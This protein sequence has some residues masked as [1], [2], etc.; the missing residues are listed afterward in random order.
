M[1][2]A[3]LILAVME[4]KLTHRIWISVYAQQFGMSENPQSLKNTIS[5]GDLLKTE[6]YR[7]LFSG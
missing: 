7:T 1:T 6:G 5:I 2:W 4:A 3:I